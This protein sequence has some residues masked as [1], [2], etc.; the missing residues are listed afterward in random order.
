MTFTH[1]I[2]VLISNFPFWKVTR[3]KINLTCY[4][5][6]FTSANSLCRHNALTTTDR[7]ISK[8]LCDFE[9]F[10]IHFIS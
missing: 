1:L 9:T 4:H 2:H 5:G 10:Y 6:N 3:K 7:K 8:D